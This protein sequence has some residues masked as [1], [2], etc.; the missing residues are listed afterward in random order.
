MTETE[1][2]KEL[3]VVFEVPIGT[4]GSHF[5]GENTDNE[6]HFQQLPTVSAFKLIEKYKEEF[7]DALIKHE[8]AVDL[9]KVS[10]E[11]GE[12]LVARELKSLLEKPEGEID[13][14]EL[15]A[16]MRAINDSKDKRRVVQIKADQLKKDAIVD[17]ALLDLVYGDDSNKNPLKSNK[18]GADIIIPKT[19]KRKK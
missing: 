18:G 15:T 16:L 9:R 5:F 7:A 8:K 6:P 10:E 12:A 4:V 13:I 14:K 2:K 11:M 17:S 19:R 3:S 1:I